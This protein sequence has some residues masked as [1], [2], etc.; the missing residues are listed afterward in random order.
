MK[1]W[2][3]AII[4]SA[5]CGAVLAAQT[6][7]PS[8]L[9]Y[10]FGTF[11]RQGR[12]FV[13]IVLQDSV[14]IDYSIANDEI[15]KTDALYPSRV[16]PARVAGPTDMRDL[17]A[18]YDAGLRQRTAYI[19][20][21]LNGLRGLARPAYAYDL[22]AVRTLPPIVPGQIVNAA[23]NYRAHGDEMAARGGIG[24]AVVQSAPQGTA[25]PGTQSASGIWERRADDSRW[26][27]YMFL[28][29]PYAVI[30]DGAAIRMP[31]GRTEI[32]WECELGV[33]IGREAKDVPPEKAGAYIFGY[34]LQNDV[35]DRGSRGDSRLGVDWLIGKSHDTFAPLGPFIVPREF[36]SDPKNLRITFVLNG[37]MLQ[38]ANTSLMIH[39]VHELL[40]YASNI[41]TLRP[42]DVLGTGTPAG[43]GSARKPPV[44]LK[45][46]D[47]SV[48]TYEGVGTLTNPVVAAS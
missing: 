3:A 35:S 46:G 12:T 39:D 29:S 22:A 9:V 13:G 45:P 37:Q 26:N 30:A 1:R 25:P 32:D 27:P 41:F 17:I 14:V 8:P 42:G 20:G 16:Q 38:D 48:C 34:T 36:I 28:K 21:M 33:V 24:A 6:A 2:T 10:K 11:E 43:V 44:Y 15:A 23:V 19:A 47:R 4:G 40:S 31:R 5:I 18:R 7:V